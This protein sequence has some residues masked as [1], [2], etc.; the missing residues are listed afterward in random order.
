MRGLKSFNN[1]SF[2][3][4][5]I[6]DLVPII[7]GPRSNRRELLRGRLAV[8]VQLRTAETTSTANLRRR[9]DVR[10]QRPFEIRGIRSGKVNLVVDSAKREFN[11]LTV[12][13][14]NFRSINIIDQLADNY[15][16]QGSSSSGFITT[17]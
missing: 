7:A 17:R 15:L 16:G 12:A 1:L 3:A 13:I 8:G 4:T 2:N 10:L 14:T 11:P 5:A 9:I 6:G